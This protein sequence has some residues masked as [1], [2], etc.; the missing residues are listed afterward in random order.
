MRIVVLSDLYP[1]YYEGGH[2][3]MCKVV[4]EGLLQRGHDV[5]V[6]TSNYGLD[7]K[8]TYN[9]VYR[10]LYSL[11]FG[12][13]KWFRK[14]WNQLRVGLYGRLNY[15]ITKKIVRE[16]RPRVVYCGQI[17]LISAYPLMAI[18]E[19][20]IPVAY[21]LAAYG[22]ANLVKG[23]ILEK[24]VLKLLYRR[25]ISGLTRLDK[26][27]VRYLMVVSEAVKKKYVEAGFR[28]SNISVIP[29][30]GMARD[31][32]R[33][34]EARVLESRKK[35]RKLLYVGR[36]VRNKGVHVAVNSV[37]YLINQLGITNVSLD[38]IGDGNP[39]FI[40]Y[41]NKLVKNLKLGG[42]VKFR[43]KMSREDVIKEYSKY[44]ILV[45]PSIWEEP[46]GIIILE[47]MSQ[48]IPVVATNVGGIPEIISDK[49]DGILVA[50]NDPIA[51][52]EKIK[53]LLEDPGLVR[54]VSINGIRLIREKY[55]D[56]KIMNQVENY[57][58][59]VAA[60]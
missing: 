48:G 43:G 11:D 9:N 57:L 41:L 3:I 53:E 16:L 1:P 24:N 58:R 38:I 23:C 18:K 47:A 21:H 49:E 7:R 36:V 55:T 12:S 28:E 19:L 17:D 59:E 32:L 15:L 25:V 50:P 5:F 51:M 22:L 2:E 27:D 52:A 14:R 20:D 46:F 42:V 6:L 8:E 44:D 13:G 56:E 30:L 26:I 60:Q 31:Q 39:E 35:E 10:L 45:V 37:G 33:M 40:A 29:P 34:V 54:K 4:A